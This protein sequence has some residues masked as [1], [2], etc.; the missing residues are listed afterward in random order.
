M[1]SKYPILEVSVDKN[2]EHRG[3]QITNDNSREVQKM[4]NYSLLI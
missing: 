3:Q 2:R 4:E 1:K